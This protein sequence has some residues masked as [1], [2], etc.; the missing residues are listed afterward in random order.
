MIA[1]T[2]SEGKILLWNVDGQLV[3]SLDRHHRPIT[4]LQFSPE[5]THIIST[6]KDGKALLWSINGRV[7]ME[8]NRESKDP[9][10]VFFSSSGDH[11][12]YVDASNNTLFQCPVPNE[13]I[14]QI[15]ADLSLYQVPLTALRAKYQIQFWTERKF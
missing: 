3:Q 10:P 14:K 7:V 2:T 11:I 1:S 12:I 4:Y 13:A 9:L 5:G 8:L 6:A 15:K